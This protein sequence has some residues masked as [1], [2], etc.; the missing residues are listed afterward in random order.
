MDVDFEWHS[1]FETSRVPVDDAD[2]SGRPSTSKTTENVEEIRELIHEDHR[3]II[4]DLTDIVGISHG[5]CQ[6]ILTENLNMRFIAAKF[7]PRLMTNDQKQRC[8][9]VC[10][11][12]REEA[13]EV[14]KVSQIENETEGTMF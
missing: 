14:T 3:Q 12:L 9:N 2:L 5:V 1:R 8:I 6:E 7:V 4:H 13:N 10:L 11:E